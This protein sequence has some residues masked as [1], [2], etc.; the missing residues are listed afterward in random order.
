MK[1][2]ILLMSLV[3]ILST[4][5][6]MGQITITYHDFPPIPYSTWEYVPTTL[7]NTDI[8]PN[9]ANQIWDLSGLIAADS[10]PI[11]ISDLANLP[12]AGQYPEGNLVF[13]K[14]N[15]YYILSRTPNKIGIIGAVMPMDTAL[16]LSIIYITPEL[17]YTYPY[18]MGSIV[19]SHPQSLT[20][21]PYN[22]TISGYF[23][24]SLAINIR[25]SVK[26]EVVGWGI[27]KLPYADIK[28]LKTLTN[29]TEN[30][31]ILAYIMGTWFEVDSSINVYNSI[32][33]QMH[34]LLYPLV[35]VKL[36][37]FNQPVNLNWIRV[38]PSLHTRNY[39]DF[40]F[41]YFPNPVQ[42]FVIFESDRN[43]SRIELISMDGKIVKLIEVVPS[44]QIKIKLNDLPTGLYVF[45]LYDSEE[46]IRLGKLIK[47]Q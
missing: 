43:I 8:S 12:F 22:D 44:P 23:V 40:S 31:T 38:D 24:D 46:L 36:D 18:T 15:N 32:E 11:Q 17:I 34:N 16:L 45:K 41:R 13:Q 21:I 33:F 7:E 6:I 47:R 27:M 39:P 29:K 3:L 20:K 5:L 30:T 42:N 14:N 35:T 9:G 28:V 19:E 26:H 2:K 25:A 37:T 1:T 4:R 10:T